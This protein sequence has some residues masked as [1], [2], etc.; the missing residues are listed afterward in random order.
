M[1]SELIEGELLGHE[2]GAFSSAMKQQKGKFNGGTIFLEEIDD[3]WL[4]V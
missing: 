4:V 3:I 1:P 2:K